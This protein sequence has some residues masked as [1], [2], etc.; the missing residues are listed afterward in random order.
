MKKSIL[1]LS[2]GAVLSYGLQAQQLLYDR[3]S[4]SSNNIS[5]IDATFP[6][7]SFSD[8]ACADI[9]GDY[10]TDIIMCGYTNGLQT[11]TLLYRNDG[12][13]NFDLV[14]GT[15]F[16]GVKNG[17]LTFGDIDS[18][19]D[20]DLFITG[21]SGLGFYVSE[22]YINGGSG[23]FS[24]HPNN[25]SFFSTGVAHSSTA[26]FD[27]NN[28]GYMDIL[29]SGAT[30][31]VPTTITKLYLQDINGNFAAS[32]MLGTS[33]G[34]VDCADITGDG[35]KDIVVTGYDNSGVESANIYVYQP[36]S[37]NW[38]MWSILTPV[39]NSCAKFLDIENDG[40]QDLILIGDDGS[41]S[42]LEVYENP[43]NGVLVLTS[44]PIS[45]FGV[46]SGGLSVG[47]VDGDGFVDV[48]ITGVI[49]GNQ[50]YTQILTNN[51][52]GTFTGDPGSFLHLRFGEPIL[53][54]IL[55]DDDGKDDL[56]QMG[57][58]TTG[59][60]KTIFYVNDNGTFEEVTEALPGAAFG[61][62]SVGDMHN[63]G[64]P[65]V[66][67]TGQPVSGTTPIATIYQGLGSDTLYYDAAY[68]TG[69]MGTSQGFAVMADLDNINGDDILYTGYDFSNN[70]VSMMHLNDGAGGYNTQTSGIAPLSL[71]D[72]A[73]GDFNNDGFLDVFITGDDGAGKIAKCYLNNQSAFFTQSA[74]FTG[75]TY[76]AVAVGY[77]NNDS[78]LDVII[79]GSNPSSIRVTQA[80]VGDGLG[81]FTAA[82]AGA[83]SNVMSGSIS[84]ADV[85]G[86]SFDD[87]FVSG[88]L[89]GSAPVA[90]LYLNNAGAGFTLASGTPFI[91]VASSDSKFFDADGDSDMDLIVA[92]ASSG[93]YITRLYLNDGSGSFSV[94]EPFP[95]VG[96][97]SAAIGIA[98]F[99]DN[100]IDDIVVSGQ[101]LEGNRTDF[102]MGYHV[103]SNDLASLLLLRSGFQIEN[104]G[105]GGPLYTLD[106][107][108]VFAEE[109]WYVTN[110]VLDWY[111]VDWVA[112]GDLRV[113][114]IDLN[115]LETYLNGLGYQ[116]KEN[117]N[118]LPSGLFS[119]NGFERLEELLVR[120]CKLILGP[121]SPWY[122]GTS[123]DPIVYTMDISNN[124]FADNNGI[125][126]SNMFSGFGALETIVARK[127]RDTTTGISPINDWI[128][129]A[130]T[131]HAAA[132][133]IL[134]ENK[135]SGTIDLTEARRPF[136]EYGAF[137]NNHFGAINSN[138]GTSPFL[139]SLSVGHNDVQDA[140]DLTNLINNAS[141]MQEL[142]ATSVM[143]DAPVDSLFDLSAVTIS[144]E[145][146]VLEIG[147]NNFTGVLDL[148]GIMG[149]TTS[150][151]SVIELWAN[152]NR[153]S[154]ID[155]DENGNYPYA[156]VIDISYNVIES[157]LP[158]T[159][160][161]E[162]PNLTLLDIS[163]N[164]FYGEF[165]LGT[166]SGKYD[167]AELMYLRFSD[168]LI[169]GAL[170]LGRL[171][172]DLFGAATYEL[173]FENNLISE[174]EPTDN[175]NFSFLYSVQARNNELDFHD[176]DVL[177][178]ELGLYH[179]PLATGEHHYLPPNFQPHNDELYYQGQSPLDTLEGFNYSP[180]KPVG[181]GGARQIEQGEFL[182]FATEIYNADTLV[183]LLGGAAD[184]EYHFARFD[185]LGNH[186]IM[187]YATY[188]FASN[189]YNITLNP[190][191]SNVDFPKDDEASGNVFSVSFDPYSGSNVYTL[192]TLS[193]YNTG[194]QKALGITVD[195]AIHNWGTFY[196]EWYYTAYATSDLFPMLTVQSDPKRI[197]VGGC[198]DSL[199]TPII[200][201]QIFVQY[202]GG[203]IF[204][205][206]PEV[207]D[208][209]K[210]ALRDSLGV[211]SVETC[212]CGDLEL[213]KLDDELYED[214]LLANG[215]GTRKAASNTSQTQGQLLS[216][217][218]NYLLMEP[219][220]G[221]TNVAANPTSN[222]TSDS[223]RIAIIDSGVDY[224]HPDIS[225]HIIPSQAPNG[226]SCQ[227]L[228]FGYSFINKTELPFDD[229]GHGTNVAGILAGAAD[230]AANV[231]GSSN[232][233][234]S[235][236]PIKYTNA[237]GKGT[238]F[239]AVC[240][241]Y[242]GIRNGAKVVNLSWGYEGEECPAL[243]DALNFADS[244]DVIV[245]CA[246]GNDTRHVDL[247]S[248]YSHWPSSYSRPVWQV[249][250]LVSVA[251][252]N[253]NDPSALAAYSNYSATAVHLAAYG[254][255]S[256]TAI[257][258][259]GS[260]A[261]E[262][263][264]GT[265]FAAPQVARAVGLLR[266][267]FP[268]ANVCQI[269]E[270]LR[271]S[272]DTLENVWYRDAL[273]WKG[274]L[275]FDRAFSV[276]DS[277]TSVSTPCEVYSADNHIPSPIANNALTVYPNPFGNTLYLQWSDNQNNTPATVSV[278]T[279]DGRLQ[280]QF[281]AADEYH[282][283]STAD[284]LPGIY[285]LRAQRGDKFYTEK[286]V[287]Y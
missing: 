170:P 225:G 169:E 143:A 10:D 215:S 176:L 247:D 180:Q 18:D 128:N 127:F 139:W 249:T 155:V 174:I 160:F 164:R 58:T 260:G 101:T 282:A 222:A 252:I 124:E 274:R 64:N 48:A 193:D 25:S 28:D 57:T 125:V 216:A 76:S 202:R 123:G 16:S 241:I 152:N 264:V 31:S 261:T 136:L 67:I 43:G 255:V 38:V 256:T 240:G 284:W 142:L 90:E 162:M 187:A 184:T 223:V 49:T 98:D 196:D 97:T 246:A 71:G 87:V 268:D 206:A 85:N 204:A 228:Q 211:T 209:V 287:K 35:Y 50:S 129:P 121:N 12:D 130:D 34:S 106:E 53:Y 20:Q 133:L 244:S 144:N 163:S 185:S 153:F 182:Q 14:T 224:D 110:S 159:V 114:K 30:T 151:G 213:W 77:L 141:A 285:I 65:D 183:T 205:G 45:S 88:D 167:L 60:F 3:V 109:A 42:I 242:M 218:P 6:G 1:L 83:F 231:A 229:Y 132:T 134:S 259:D 272:V 192:D 235:I 96:V 266:Y 161:N 115:L 175:T 279:F 111:G 52:N 140:G 226:D 112:E 39:G 217:N 7:L 81:N 119:N 188:N 166:N 75:L 179:A 116:L 165:P 239:H 238:L 145:L 89:N 40:D 33:H 56:I 277:L 17:D 248:S 108:N 47:D 197:L 230:Y 210:R 91:A 13:N 93:G 131:F 191:I 107:P 278:Y 171:Y 82:F 263:V 8:V 99:D 15:P 5:G 22:L 41:G 37:F 27:A 201:Q 195:S 21:D 147:H 198:F 208:S 59:T 63:D 26:I 80:Y 149:R 70:K 148:G 265:S 156:S 95:F 100:G 273:M 186:E 61:S 286:V 158:S 135:L 219:V 86:D 207:S 46:Q 203:T 214:F 283:V 51:Q 254:D 181:E 220:P 92:G 189:D 69:L 172:D 243:H 72:G 173:H 270:A 271:L 62:I 199:G 138:G 269:K 78:N 236:M 178:W 79:S 258:T 4:I 55:G 74:S 154:G 275:N 54:D 281:V 221:T 250:N 117:V 102:Y 190:A 267:Y 212:P 177:V 2:V 245:V 257:D 19:G 29:V 73:V 150:T 9:D 157:P 262:S 251:S 200:C 146:S 234:I 227:L 232:N 120:D 105:G 113:R 276:L 137:E 237:T 44:A 66:L 118:T 68:S 32:N 126:L 11:V 280:T 253:P 24:L 103:N 122:D 104:L 233:E 168:N 36:A 194:N 23:N 94:L 84:I